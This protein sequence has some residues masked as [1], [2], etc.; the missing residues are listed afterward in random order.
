MCHSSLSPLYKIKFSAPIYDESL[1][2]ANRVQPGYGGG[3]GGAAM[4][5]M[6]PGGNMGGGSIGGGG[7]GSIGGGVARYDESNIA[8]TTNN[9]INI[10][11]AM[12][13]GGAAGGGGTLS[14]ACEICQKRYNSQRDLH[15]HQEA[16]G[17]LPAGAGAND[18]AMQQ[19]YG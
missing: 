6:Q 17:H 9:N 19:L 16:R 12:Y 14:F 5:L 15:S 8:A 11:N 3:G 7:G 2:N 4:M 13:A 10:N 1:M 18:V